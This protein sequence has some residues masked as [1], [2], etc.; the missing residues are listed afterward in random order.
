MFSQK[1]FYVKSEYKTKS[2]E[3]V[4]ELSVDKYC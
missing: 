4:F 2:N 3:N 1:H